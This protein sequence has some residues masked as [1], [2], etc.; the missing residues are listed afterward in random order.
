M[1]TPGQMVFEGYRDFVDGIAYDGSGIPEWDQLNPNIRDGWEAGASR[2]SN[3]D[4]YVDLDGKRVES[5][6]V[7]TPNAML[8]AKM[9]HLL[10]EMERYKLG[11]KS[12]KGR[13]YAR[14][15]SHLEDAV[16]YMRTFV[17]TLEELESVP[18][19]N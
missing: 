18:Q 7:T 12:E 6:V 16:A 14:T 17:L 19:V 2:V 10:G 5:L 3:E 8:Y 9:S 1:K 11:Q 13:F 15:Y 4:V